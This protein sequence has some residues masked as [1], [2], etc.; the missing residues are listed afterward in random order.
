MWILGKHRLIVGDAR[1]P[2]VF[3]KLMAGE[4]AQMAISDPPYNVPIEGHVCGLGTVKHAEF[5]MASGEMSEAEFESFLAVT[6]G[7]LA[8]FSGDGS[9]HY[10]FMDRRHMSEILAAGRSA[11]TELKNLVVWNKDNG[12]MGTFYRSKHELV[13]VFKNGTGKHV[14]NFGL[15]ENGR[16]RTNV[17]DYA[18]VSS[19]GPDRDAQLAMHPT[20]KPVAMIADAIRDC[21]KRNGLVLDAFSGSGTVIIAAEETGRRA[22]AIEID[23]H[24]ADVSVRRWEAMT[25]M[26]AVLEEGGLRSTWRTGAATDE[27]EGQ[28]GDLLPFSPRLTRE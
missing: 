8:R 20:V 15:G 21:S 5:A 13:F 2:A 22:R 27:P 1:D 23:P 18:G 16:Y 9:I 12:G 19:L 3:E 26:P 7:N 6:L 4:L 10:V 14:N 28:R 24:Y 11:Y 17:W 25:G